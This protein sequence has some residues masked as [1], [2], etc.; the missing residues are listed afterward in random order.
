MTLTTEAKK[1]IEE[2]EL[3]LANIKAGLKK[4][5]SQSQVDRLA[6]SQR[7]AS[8]RDEAAK[9]RADDLPALFDQMHTQRALYEHSSEDD[10]PDIRSPYFAHMKLLE[11]G[12]TRDVLLGHKTFLNVKGSPIIDWRNAPISRIFF[13]YREGEEFEEELPGRLSE[14]VVIVRRIITIHEGD[15]I[16]IMTPEFSLSKIKGEWQRDKQGLIP[17]LRGGAGSA[18]RSQHVLGTG[19]TQISG[20]EVSALL[21]PTQFELLSADSNEPLLIL[22]GAGCGKTTVALHRIAL[23]HFQDPKRFTQNSMIVIVPEQGL[24]R[25]SRKLLDSL[26][27]PLVEVTT[28]DQW[29]ERQAR[30]LIR[31]LPKRVYDSTPADVIRY[32]RHPA[33]RHAFTALIAK[34]LEELR[35]DL[36][37]KIPGVKPFLKILDQED[38]P[39]I[40]K[41]E[42]IEA[43]LTEHIQSQEGV[44]SKQRI[45]VMREQFQKFKKEL[46]DI[47]RD[48]NELFTNETIIQTVIASSGGGLRPG[49]KNTILSHSLDQMASS[50]RQDF[51]GVDDSKLAMVDAAHLLKKVK[52]TNTTPSMLKI[53]PYFWS[54]CS[55]RVVPVIVVTVSFD[56][57]PI[58]LSTKPKILLQSSST[59]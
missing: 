26:G 53:L 30:L 28:F 14:G 58:L 44:S 2:E 21:D 35:R 16:R 34:Q 42:I 8:L 10:L 43:K 27:L 50:S 13:N 40:G 20:P 23:L 5:G 6:L 9:A 41:V 47:N 32:K 55:V 18:S 39:L 37:L 12:K 36:P 49:L 51:S 15:L 29:I 19:N 46:L 3:L 33:I 48:R 4:H 57:F 45:K 7:L 54:Y 31:S 52:K 17:T 22:G 56:S 25:L 59:S 1:L 24:V 38:L 11:K